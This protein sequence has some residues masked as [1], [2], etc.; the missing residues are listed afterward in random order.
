MQHLRAFAQTTTYLGLAMILI[1]WGG[2]IYFAH[3]EHR[4]AY[5]DA[6]RQGSNLAGIFEEYIARVIGGSDT[7]LVALREIYQKDPQHFD[8]AN[9]TESDWS[10][11]NHI[12]QF[13]I[14]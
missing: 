4:R 13:T 2:V 10:Q 14:V 5:E 9:L 12:V 3:Q 8:I 6:V 7:T 11:S 1:I